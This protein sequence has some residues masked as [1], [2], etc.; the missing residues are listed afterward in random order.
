M[1]SVKPLSLL[2]EPLQSEPLLVDAQPGKVLH[3]ALPWFIVPDLLGRYGP[4]HDVD[5]F[6]D[7]FVDELVDLGA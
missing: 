5:A 6:P 1:Y 4:T 3:P 7:L 2:D